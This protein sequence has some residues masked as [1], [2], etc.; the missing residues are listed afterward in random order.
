MKN[1]RTIK[2]L[3][4]PRPLAGQRPPK[5][6]AGGLLGL[7]AA[8]MLTLGLAYAHEG[9]GHHDEK[10]EAQGKT[11][12]AESVTVTG[13]VLDLSCYLGHGSAGKE[14]QQ[15]AKDCLLK[16][17]VPAGLLTSDGTVYLLVPDHKHEKAFVSVPK[18]A[19]QQIKVTGKRVMQG[20]LQAILVEKAEKI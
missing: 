17:H 13:E 12:I 15:C 19:A 3:L 4:G 20:G 10:A 8:S 9:H 5:L 6:C 7:A 1:K 2:G 18:M 14:H 16:L 11:A